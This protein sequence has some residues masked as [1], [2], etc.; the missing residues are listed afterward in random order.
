MILWTVIRY[1]MIFYQLLLRV[2]LMII[3]TVQEEDI[4]MRG[5]SYIIIS[6]I[7]LLPLLI[8]TIILVSLIYLFINFHF[9]YLIKV[10]A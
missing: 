3:I 9:E 5:N 10:I 7:K 6:F 4:F 1:F 2:S 8:I